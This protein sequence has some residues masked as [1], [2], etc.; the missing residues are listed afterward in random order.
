MFLLDICIIM[1]KRHMKNLY[2]LTK[3][4]FHK[5]V[6]LITAELIGNW[7]TLSTK[8]VHDSGNYDYLMNHFKYRI[9]GTL[10]YPK[11]YLLLYH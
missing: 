8:N 2:I 10:I 4:Y 6:F 7:L 9:C 5:I 1:I 3:Q 11:G